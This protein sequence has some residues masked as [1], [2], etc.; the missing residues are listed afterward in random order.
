M[1]QV[2][3]PDDAAFERQFEV[4]STA[5]DSALGLVDNALRHR[6]VELRRQGKLFVYIGPDDVLVALSGMQR[7]DP[8]GLFSRRP[9][10]ARAKRMFD[11]VCASMAMLRQL[12]SMFASGNSELQ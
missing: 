7:N 10:E 8:D 11:D 5:P 12:K 9:G 3:F 2:K 6:L 4:Y 1:D